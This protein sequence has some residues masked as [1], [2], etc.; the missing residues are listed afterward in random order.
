MLKENDD[1]R[2]KFMLTKMKMVTI[3]GSIAGSQMQSISNPNITQQKLPKQSLMAYSELKFIEAEARLG[4]GS[5][6][7]VQVSTWWQPGAPFG[8]NWCQ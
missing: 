5:T 6:A 2:L 3:I 8:A 7:L 1:P 4:L